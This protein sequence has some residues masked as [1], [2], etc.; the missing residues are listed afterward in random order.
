VTDS[1]DSSDNSGDSV[2]VAELTEADS[3]AK[4]W[5][6]TDWRG[7]SNPLEGLSSPTASALGFLSDR[8][9]IGW[10]KPDILKIYEFLVTMP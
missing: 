1:D 7:V 10:E 4:A 8:R 5:E 2:V 6:A 9:I 3:I